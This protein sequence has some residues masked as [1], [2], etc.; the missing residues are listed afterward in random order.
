[1][2]F[3][4]H[5]FYAADTHIQQNK[6]KKSH[7][8]VVLCLL[9]PFVIYAS[10]NH[11]IASPASNY[12][13]TLKKANKGNAKAM[14]LVGRML[15]QGKGTRKNIQEASKWYQR[16]ASQNYAAA[17]ARLGKLYLEGISVNK[18]TK[19]AFRLLNLAA[20]QGVPI[21]QFHLAILYEIGIGT[22]KDF[23]K[24]IKWYELAAKGGYFSAKSNSSKLRKQIGLSLATTVDNLNLK[25]EK[26][27]NS[28]KQ[29]I[30]KID[31]SQET[32]EVINEPIELGDPIIDDDKPPSLSDI[33][34]ETLAQVVANI[35]V[36]IESDVVNLEVE[37]SSVDDND[38][39]VD[40]TIEN[41]DNSDIK[42]KEHELAI[43]HQIDINGT[44]NNNETPE[45]LND[46]ANRAAVEPN[47]PP[48]KITQLA[49]LTKNQKLALL[50]NEHIKRTL[51]TL[52]EG[53]W[54]DKNR[55]VNF[56]PSP[57]TKCNII[58]N[59]DI[60]CIS[61]ELQRQTDNE[62]VFYKTFGKVSKI[63]SKGSFLIQYQN[64]VT[65]VIAD[66]AANDGAELFK[67]KIK[68]GLQN[69]IHQLNCQYKDIRNLICLRDRA[70]R[71]NFKNRAIIKKS[72]DVVDT[73]EE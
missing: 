68:I 15:E 52:L 60:K 8:V 28:T 62:T 48:I 1:M 41:D 38:V 49:N 58:N 73:E 61:R 71:Y 51:K 50:E 64:S 13:S 70:N 33:E 9:L 69:K 16:S 36:D 56:L 30:G 17:N 26:P 55:P 31:L 6:M 63:T 66:Q 67:S 35:E 19:K 3:N 44:Q 46:T 57:K 72:L 7:L 34:P 11:A 23:K 20:I 43:E 54:F 10:C 29:G 14:F 4:V 47:K 45:L 65:R 5:F 2:V 32:T 59:S 42:N 37:D 18:N 27:D 21:A 39:D 53:R 24:A 40:V 22:K 12:K 25:N